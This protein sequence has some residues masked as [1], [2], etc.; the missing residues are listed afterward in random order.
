MGEVCL[1]D[2]NRDDFG[3]SARHRPTCTT[4]R[5]ARRRAR[6]AK[7][8]QVAQIYLE[9]RLHLGN[10]GLIAAHRRGRQKFGG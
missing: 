5:E 2:G 9:T 6:L 4:I 3:R 8:R 7:T 1:D 10:V